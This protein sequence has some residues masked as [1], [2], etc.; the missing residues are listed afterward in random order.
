MEICVFSPLDEVAGA[1]F[2]TEGLARPEKTKPEMPAP[3][4]F[5]KPL[6]HTGFCVVPP[7]IPC[8]AYD[9]KKSHGLL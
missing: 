2:N 1:H 4:T 8:V 9:A 6:G 7:A 3:A 5:L